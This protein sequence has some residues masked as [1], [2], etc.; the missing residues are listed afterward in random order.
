MRVDSDEIHF[1]L[2]LKT[3]QELVL[4]LPSRKNIPGSRH[5]LGPQ[6]HESTRQG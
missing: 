3:K 2:D 4:L 5:S 6:K 1:S